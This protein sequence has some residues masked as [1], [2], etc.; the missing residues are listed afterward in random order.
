[1]INCPCQKGF[2]FKVFSMI[3]IENENLIVE[4]T[5][6]GGFLTRIY[7]KRKNKEL[8]YDAKGEWEYSDHVLFPV[9]GANNVYGLYGKSYA[10]PQRHGFA[11]Y[12]D[13]EVTNQQGSSVSICL[14]KEEGEEKEYPFAFEMTLTYSLNGNKLIREGEVLNKGEDPLVFQFGLHPAFNVDFSK[15]SLEIGEGTTLFVL[16]KD[17]DI[18]KETPWPFP[19][20]WSIVRAEVADKDTLVLDNPTKK[21]VLNNGLGGKIQL[22]TNCP[23]Y[24]LWTPHKVN[25]DDFLCVESWYGI[26]PYKG[27]P[28]D[29]SRR[30]DVN[31]ATI[32]KNFVD[33]YIFD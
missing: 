13:F 10:L 4:I 8:L 18:Y 6:K 11:F 30:R 5:L 26:S 27:M 12:S 14:K 24:A 31:V 25:E 17:G 21:I 32:S 1:M 20:S 28:Q 23:Y 22:L 9:I 3:K 33:T 2:N 7:D 29:L 15:A 16:G 19:S